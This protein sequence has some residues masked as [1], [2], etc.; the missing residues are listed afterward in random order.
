MT[1][2]HYGLVA[3]AFVA[4]AATGFYLLDEKDAEVERYRAK[5]NAFDQFCRKTRLSLESAI[6]GL[7]SNVAARQHL[8]A[9][10]MSRE[11]IHRGHASVE[12]CLGALTPI[13]ADDLMNCL[14]QDNY[15]C[16]AKQVH[17]YRDALVKAG[18]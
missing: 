1:Y 13:V 10:M 4:V 2:K 11:S 15:A 17:A 7:E 8:H 16:I 18:W 12:T 6:T 5:A 3:F 14:M 9:D